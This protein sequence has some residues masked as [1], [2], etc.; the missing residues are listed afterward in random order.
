M[1]QVKSLTPPEVVQALLDG[2]TV[3]F[4]GNLFCYRDG[5]FASRPQGNPAGPPWRDVAWRAGDLLETF[6][7][8]PPWHVVPDTY[9][10]TEARKRMAAGKRVRRPVPDGWP[11]RVCYLTLSSG[12]FGRAGEPFGFT[13]DDFD[14]TD[15]EDA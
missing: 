1:S 12:Y 14:A 10:W 15:W 4:N 6:I 8:S 7:G 5:C 2:K 11:E 9:D 13:P 3:A